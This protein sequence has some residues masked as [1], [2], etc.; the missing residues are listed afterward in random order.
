[1]LRDLSQK[2]GGIIRTREQ[3][4]ETPAT[5]MTAHVHEDKPGQLWF[6]GTSKRHAGE[7][8][9]GQHRVSHEK[10]LGDVILYMQERDRKKAI[11]SSLTAKS[12]MNTLHSMGTCGCSHVT[13]LKP[14]A[15]HRASLKEF[16]YH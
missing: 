16:R 8:D 10:V 4:Y 12:K 2:G 1:M 5:R 3:L 7:R 9:S 11:P 15:P 13:T 6:T 14:N